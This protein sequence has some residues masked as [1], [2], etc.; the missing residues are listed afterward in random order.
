M[1]NAGS[2]RLVIIAMLGAGHRS[3]SGRLLADIMT[4]MMYGNSFLI[5]HWNGMGE[6]LREISLDTCKCNRDTIAIEVIKIS[7]M[8]KVVNLNHLN[9]SEIMN[10]S[11][12]CFTALAIT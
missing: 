3:S 2:T 11:N 10:D 8:L 4:M 5:S 9:L 12:N 1:L 7:Q 6:N